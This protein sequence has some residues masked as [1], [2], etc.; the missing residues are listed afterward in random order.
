MSDFVFTPSA[1]VTL[2]V[3]TSQQRFPVRRIY[4]VGRNYSDHIRE[5]GGDPDRETPFFF[6][7]PTDSVV[8]NGERIPY[9]MFTSDFQ[10]EIEMFIGIGKEGACIALDDALD[11]VFGVGVCIDL[12]RRD[13]QIAARQAGRPWEIGK[14]FDQSAP[15]SELVPTHSIG[16][17]HAGAIELRVNGETRQRGDLSQ[18]IWSP[19]EVIQQLSTQYR[20]MPGDLVMTGTPAGVGPLSPGDHVVATIEGV[21]TLEIEVIRPES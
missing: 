2:P 5:M 10:H 9:P 11:H 1:R 19:A 14:S 21:A 20:L 12:T 13:V 6:Q 17:P 4:C 16:F 15:C 18:M 3:H 8:A 7:K